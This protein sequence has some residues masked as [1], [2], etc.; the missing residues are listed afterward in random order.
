M[1]ARWYGGKTPIVLWFY[2]YY[3]LRMDQRTS[4]SPLVRQLRETEGP[5][6]AASQ[7]L[8]LAKGDWCAAY[9]SLEEKANRFYSRGDEDGASLLRLSSRIVRFYGRGY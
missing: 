5:F 3:D 4:N 6:L 1:G 8:R 9:S 7:A 2:K